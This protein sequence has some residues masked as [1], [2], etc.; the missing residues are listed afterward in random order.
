MLRNLILGRAVIRLSLET[1]NVYM[2]CWLVFGLKLIVMTC[3]HLWKVNLLFKY[4]FTK[5]KAMTILV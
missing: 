5:L 3:H 1:Y 4:L 2:K